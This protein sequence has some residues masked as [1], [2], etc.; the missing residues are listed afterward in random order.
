[1]SEGEPLTEV[2]TPSFSDEEPFAVDLLDLLNLG[3]SAGIRLGSTTPGKLVQ[4]FGEPRIRS[5]GADPHSILLNFDS[6]SAYFRGGAR[7][8]SLSYNCHPDYGKLE[9]WSVSEQL[10]YDNIGLADLWI[11]AYASNYSLRL[12]GRCVSY[13]STF[14][15]LIQYQPAGFDFENSCAC[16]TTRQP[17]AC[18]GKA[19]ST[20]AL[21]GLRIDHL[22][23]PPTQRPHL[24]RLLPC[25]IANLRFQRPAAGLNFIPI[26]EQLRVAHG[27][28]PPN[29]NDR[30]AQ[31]SVRK[32]ATY[33]S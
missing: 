30:H 19:G 9:R 15:K 21:A 27:A 24:F 13:F 18:P 10:G 5:D 20:R 1:M 3:H 16:R 17:P 33:A 4:L 25:R 28:D 31:L 7:L 8:F 29:L 11:G 12:G 26:R 6:G 14:P 2:W 22:R 23:R 32:T